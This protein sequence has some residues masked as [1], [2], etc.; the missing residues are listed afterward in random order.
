[1]HVTFTHPSQF[2]LFDRTDNG[3]YDVIWVN[4]SKCHYLSHLITCLKYVRSCLLS[5]QE[6]Q[7]PTGKTTNINRIKLYKSSW[8]DK[9]KEYNREYSSNCLVQWNAIKRSKTLQPCG[10]CWPTYVI[11][12]NNTLPLCS[13]FSNHSTNGELHLHQEIWPITGIIKHRIDV[14]DRFAKKHISKSGL[15]WIIICWPRTCVLSQYFVCTVIRHRKTDKVIL[16][17]HNSSSMP[18]IL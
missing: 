4:K 8:T 10:S 9:W 15:L 14:T 13:I 16:Q 7:T 5:V 1:M 17:L 18:P 3:Y 6:E 12:G 2:C 11:M